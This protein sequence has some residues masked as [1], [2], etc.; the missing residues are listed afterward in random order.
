MLAGVNLLGRKKDNPP[1]DDTDAAAD[2]ESV[3]KDSGTTAPKGLVTALA[4]TASEINAAA[5]DTFALADVYT[6]QGA[7]PARYRSDA[8]WMANNLIYNRIRQFDTS[9]GGGFWAN[10]NDGRPPQL[11]GRSALEAEAMDA[12][13]GGAGASSSYVLAF[14]DFDNYVIADRIGMTVEF[15]P[16][17]FRQA[18]AGAG[19][20]LPTGQRGW[21]A[22]YR[23]GADVVSVNAFRLLDVASAA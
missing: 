14:G 22:Y 8:S 2:S 12:T 15:I 3:A 17:L 5:D 21:Y 19:F 16:H 10:L 6:I 18:T 1:P 23:T 7:L 20:G 11:L 9:G 13:F 4:G